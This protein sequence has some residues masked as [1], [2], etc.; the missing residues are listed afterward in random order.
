MLV[1]VSEFMDETGLRLLRRRC[2][3]EYAPDL[4][5]DPA[6]LRARLAGADALVVRN[7]TRVDDAL[8]AAAPRL[9][10]V[11]RLGAGLD[12]LDL[13]AARA[14]RVTVVY[15]PEANADSVAE[16]TLALLLALARR[17][18]EAD[19]HT[20]AGGWAR[21]RFLGTEL[22]GKTLAVLGLGRTGARVAARARALGMRV[23]AWHPRRAPDD[24]IWRRSG[25]MPAGERQCFAMADA[26]T[27]HLPLTA[28][29]RGFVDRT[30][31]GWLRPHA[32]LVNTSR[33]EVVDEE[34]LLEA[35]RDGRLGGAAL[36]VRR[37]EP[38]PAPDPL[39]GLPNVILTPHV[40]GLTVEAQR[41]V[42][43]TV[44]ADV[45][46]VLAGRRP[47]FPAPDA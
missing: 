38:P 30:R 2:D 14:R 27:I 41:R 47:R 28:E 44:A 31:L 19:R 24:P 40:A 13:P 12:N 9:R 23:I 10:V 33:G 5:A 32:L 29:T 4:W 6:G 8:L 34:A 46:R 21:E 37:R 11:G 35:L 42:A 39:A 22:S 15:A 26:L 1:V 17:L 45:L 3:V 7:Q 25:A 43:E 20:R 36:D 18:P 16:H